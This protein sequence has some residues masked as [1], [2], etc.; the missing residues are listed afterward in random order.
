[1]CFPFIQFVLFADS[2]FIDLINLFIKEQELC[3]KPAPM[4]PREKFFL[5]KAFGQS[6]QPI[7][8]QSICDAV[9]VLYPRTYK[10]LA[11]KINNGGLDDLLRLCAPDTVDTAASA[12]KEALRTKCLSD[13]QRRMMFKYYSIAQLTFN[14]GKCAGRF[15][16]FIAILSVFKVAI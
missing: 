1:M 11:K 5:G 6:S 13:L 12:G 16:E 7:H 3:N 15:S 2:F 8:V 14:M 10:S 4:E 9:A